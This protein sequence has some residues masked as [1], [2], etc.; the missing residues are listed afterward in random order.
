MKPRTPLFFYDQ[1]MLLVFQIMDDVKFDS[2]FNYLLSLLD[3][4]ELFVETAAFDWLRRHMHLIRRF[5]I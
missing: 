5:K 2:E 4:S 1:A 3:K